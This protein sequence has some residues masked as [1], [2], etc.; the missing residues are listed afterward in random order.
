MPSFGAM[1]I[2]NNI[3]KNTGTSL[4]ASTPQ[5][6]PMRRTNEKEN[7]CTY[8]GYVM[9]TGCISTIYA[10]PIGEIS[11]TT[12]E[13][14]VSTDV[15]ETTGGEESTASEETSTMKITDSEVPGSASN[16]YQHG[17]E[18]GLYTNPALKDTVGWKFQNETVSDILDMSQDPNLEGWTL[19][20]F[21]ADTVFQGLREDD[22]VQ[23]QAEGIENMNDV[24]AMMP[25]VMSL[26]DSAILDANRSQ[27][28]T[29]F[30]MVATIMTMAHSMK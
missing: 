2:H 15:S 19:D 26:D 21:F 11:S 28:V 9:T 7:Y 16:W 30:R 12:Q 1:V 18:Q 29:S 14:T 3:L 13:T 23:L 20:S 27:W 17:L 4:K 24:L 10:A 8:H 22:L 25:A 6:K 5:R